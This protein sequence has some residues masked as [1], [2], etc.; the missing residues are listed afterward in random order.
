MFPMVKVAVLDDYQNLAME[1]VDWSVLPAHVGIEAFHDHL[2]DEDAI[3]ERLK[4]FDIVQAMRERT[5]FGRS[6]LER[7]PNLKLL[8]TTAMINRAI[9]M[10]AASDLGIVVEG[11]DKPIGAKNPGAG[12]STAHLAWGLIIA[13][14]MNIVKEDRAIREGKWQVDIGT[15][16]DGKT[17]GVLGLGRLG[18]R[19]ATIALGFGMNVIAWSQSLTPE[20]ATEWR[21]TLVT[22]EQLFSQSDIVTIHYVLTDRSRGLVGK[23]ELALMKPT[24]YLINTSRGPLVDETALIDALRRRA[25]AGAGIDTFDEEPLPVDHPFRSM[26]NVILTPH[27]GYVTREAYES[28]YACAVE[29]IQAFVGGEYTRVLNSSVLRS[30]S[31]RHLGDTRD[32]PGE[33]TTTT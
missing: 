23:R 19:M 12:Y 24:A 3:V 25:I 10:E 33:P 18:S 2:S 17:L 8:I 32:E 6:L 16:L 20:R 14:T 7:L 9:D 13:L 30:S 4:E 1:L 31:L 28:W 22:K 5:P 26:D 21:A 29:N 27:I 15:S 11:T